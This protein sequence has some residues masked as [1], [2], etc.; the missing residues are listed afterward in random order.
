LPAD[1]LKDERSQLEAFDE[2]I[3]EWR[4]KLLRDLP[5]TAEGGT[6]YQSEEYNERWRQTA[7][8]WSTLINREMPLALDPQEV[9]EIRNDLLEI[10]GSLAAY[11]VERPLD[12]V[13]STMLH[14]EAIRHVVRD[15]IDGHVVPE[16]DARELLRGL[17]TKLPR[18]TRRDLGNLLGT[19]E[20][21]IQRILKADHPVEPSRRLWLVARLV[22]LLRRAWTPEGVVAWFF[23]PRAE[24]DGAPP[25]DVLDDPGAES[26]ILSA[27]KQGRAQHGP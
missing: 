17:E 6:P 22:D 20:R 7:A 10:F 5:D 15:A 1:A 12:S 19:S 9:A 26:R 21:S 8:E 11:D 16:G 27:A 3:G 4:E 23:R 18:I 2:L 13:E 24:L 25:F 14:L